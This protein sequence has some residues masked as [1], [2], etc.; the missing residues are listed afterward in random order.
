MEPNF[1]VVGEEKKT[2]NNITSTPAVSIPNGSVSSV[3]KT[4][5]QQNLVNPPL[6]QTPAITC[7]SLLNSTTT[8][9]K[10][11]GKTILDLLE[12]SPG[13]N[14]QAKSITIESKPVANQVEKIT[15]ITAASNALP[16]CSF[17]GLS[18]KPL[19]QFTPPRTIKP[20][21]SVQ[22]SLPSRSS[23]SR[24]PAVNI[25]SPRQVSNIPGT[26]KPVSPVTTKRMPPCSLMS[27]PTLPTQS[28]TEVPLSPVS[29]RQNYNFINKLPSSSLGYKFQLQPPNMSNKIMENLQRT[30]HSNH[31]S[32]NFLD[33]APKSITPLSSSSLLSS[34]AR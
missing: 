31:L 34:I 23:P 8:K 7:S 4:V 16:S 15:V 19:S 17:Q 32:T 13:R 25:A 3:V 28:K 29:P 2:E 21:I 6:N 20:P 12:S 1:K 9:P 27:S 10:V 14:T 26:F 18:S 24:I 33:L 30:T 22:N 11:T 5:V